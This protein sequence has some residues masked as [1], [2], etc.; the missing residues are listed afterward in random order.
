MQAI[1][2]DWLIFAC[3]AL[4]KTGYI[5]WWLAEHVAASVAISSTQESS[6]ITPEQLCRSVIRRIRL[7]RR[8]GLRLT[9]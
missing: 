9:P 6:V 8:G 5:R 3:V 1:R 2:Q 7:L 4:Q